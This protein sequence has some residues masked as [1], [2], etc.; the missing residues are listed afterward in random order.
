MKCNK[1]C[2]QLKTSIYKGSNNIVFR[3]HKKAGMFVI[4]DKHILLVQSR[5]RLWGPPK[6]TMEIGET[7]IEC[8]MRELYEETGLKIYINSQCPSISIKE[9][10]IYYIVHHP[11]SELSVQDSDVNSLGWINIDCLRESIVSGDILVTRHCKI[12]IQRIFKTSV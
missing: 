6:G 12:L 11:K 9:Q 4:N 7:S 1:G 10:G 8:A 3:N 5:G 2:C